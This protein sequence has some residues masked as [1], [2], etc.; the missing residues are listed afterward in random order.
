MFSPRKTPTILFLGQW[1]RIQV[2]TKYVPERQRWGLIEG[3]ELIRRK[4][5]GGIIERNSK[6]CGSWVTATWA[7]SHG[8]AHLFT[9]KLKE[10]CFICHTMKAFNSFTHCTRKISYEEY[11]EINLFIILYFKSVFLLEKLLPLSWL[12]IAS[13]SFVI[14]MYASVKFVSATSS[15]LLNN[16]F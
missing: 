8:F 9:V 11:Y 3:Q 6:S 5:L 10:N 4:H 15:I 13:N 16:L 7:T 14:V 12:Q 2:T 1:I